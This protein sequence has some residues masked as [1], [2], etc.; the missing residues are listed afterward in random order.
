MENLFDCDGRRF[1]AKILRV[2][3][4][5]L[6][7]V[8]DDSVYLCQNIADGGDCTDKKGFKFSWLYKDRYG[9]VSGGVTDFRLIDEEPQEGDWVYVSNQFPECENKVKR[10]FICKTK[11]GV[12]LCVSAGYIKEY[13]TGEV[14]PAAPWKY[15]KQI[16]KEVITEITAEEALEIVAKQKGISVEN[17]RI[18]K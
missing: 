5:G 18:K 3:C 9:E 14:F 4:E 7:T 11:T 13:L 16:P 17:L 12:N 6:I 2:F 15:I 1:S 10:M 8:E